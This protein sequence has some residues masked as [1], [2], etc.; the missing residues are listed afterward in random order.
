MLLLKDLEKKSQEIFEAN[1]AFSD[2]D[3]FNTTGQ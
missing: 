2:M 3:F 1:A